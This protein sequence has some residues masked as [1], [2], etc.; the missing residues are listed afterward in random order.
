MQSVG[1]CHAFGDGRALCAPTGPS[2][3][4]SPGRFQ[5]SPARQTSSPPR[6]VGGTVESNGQGHPGAEPC[7]DRACSPTPARTSAQP[8]FTAP[9]ACHRPRGHREKE[10]ARLAK[11]TRGAHPACTATTCCT[12]GTLTRG[13]TQRRAA[14]RRGSGYVDDGARAASRDS[15]SD[16][17]D[18]TFD[19]Q[20]EGEKESIEEAVSGGA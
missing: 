10:H 17:K 8:S 7:C 14:T 20:R 9:G 5:Y 11:P 3:P 12:R 1:A 18:S 19:D 16:G 15:S 6:R 2:Q 13:A 4:G